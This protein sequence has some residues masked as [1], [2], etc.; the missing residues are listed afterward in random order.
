V[1]ALRVP[2]LRERREDIP[3]LVEHFNA[4]VSRRHGVPMKRFEPGVLDAF[5]RYA[6]P[7]NVREI[8]TWWKAWSC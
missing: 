8:R 5:D 4:E 1:T 6:W 7:G 2:S 3:T